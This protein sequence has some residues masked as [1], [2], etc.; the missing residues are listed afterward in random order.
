MEFLPEEPVFEY[1]PEPEVYEIPDGYNGEGTAPFAFSHQDVEESV[2]YYEPE[3][4]VYHTYGDDPA[5]LPPMYGDDPASLPPTEE[6]FYMEGP[7]MEVFRE[8]PIEY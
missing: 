4:V 7:T 5:S 8:E 1:V 6:I 2:T 3:E